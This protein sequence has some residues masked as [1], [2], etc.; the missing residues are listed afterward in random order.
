MKEHELIAELLKDLPRAPEQVNLPF[1]SDAEILP[2]GALAGGHLLFSTDEFSEEDLFLMQDSYTLGRNVCAATLSDIVASGGQPLYYAHS[3][4]VDERFTAAY[5]KDFYRGVGQVLREAGACFIGGDFGRAREWRCCASAVGRAQ[6]PI[7]RSGARPGDFL[8]LTGPCGAGNLAAAVN[9]YGVPL[10]RHLA[11]AFPLRVEALPDLTQHA[12]AAIDTSDGVFAAACT[13]ARMSG[14][15]FALENI[16]YLKAGAA[17][18]K[19]ARLPVEMLLLCECGEYEILFASPRELPYHK[20]GRVTDG[21]RTLEGRDVSHIDIS[22]REFP[23]L[24]DYLE[25]VK[26]IC[27]AL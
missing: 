5:L 10:A 18:A 2:L 17:A 25:E 14:V 20:I 6:R 13:L 9:L 27:A 26:R 22:A 1:E 15:G 12:T 24:K 8:Y 11:P 23:G 16:P 19:L 4:T 21:A 3:L 7:L